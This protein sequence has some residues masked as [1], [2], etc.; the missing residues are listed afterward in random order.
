MPRAG[1]EESGE[2]LP[3]EAARAGSGYEILDYNNPRGKRESSAVAPHLF[4]ARPGFSTGRPGAALV[5]LSRRSQCI[6]WCAVRAQDEAVN[7]FS[8]ILSDFS[9]FFLFFFFL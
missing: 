9:R 6:A 7:F 1:G 4:P 5:L 3:L 8:F 2:K